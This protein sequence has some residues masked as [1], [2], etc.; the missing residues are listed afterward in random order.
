MKKPWLVAAAI[1]AVWGIYAWLMPV[2]LDEAYYLTWTKNLAFG[3]FDHPPGVAWL[4]S[5]TAGQGSD[6]FS[7]RLATLGAGLV[8]ITGVLHFFHGL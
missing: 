4:L 3:Y 8:T 6:I 1:L 5:L 7:V 2:V